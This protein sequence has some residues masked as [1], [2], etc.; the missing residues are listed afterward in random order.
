V[1]RAAD[2]STEQKLLRAGANDIVSPYKASGRAMA[3]LALANEPAKATSA[4]GL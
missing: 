3:R 1:A 4:T 2:E